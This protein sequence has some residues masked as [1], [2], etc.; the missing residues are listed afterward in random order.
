MLRERIH[1]G[2]P[3]HVP[4]KYLTVKS[5]KHFVEALRKSY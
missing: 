4:R 1:S 5:N 3:M 2:Y